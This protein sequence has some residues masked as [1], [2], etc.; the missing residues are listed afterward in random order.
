MF[1]FVDASAVQ[2]QIPLISDPR[3]ELRMEVAGLSNSK[4]ADS[5]HLVLGKSISYLESRFRFSLR[6]ILVR[7]DSDCSRN[8]RIS[9]LDWMA[10]LLTRQA[11]PP[12]TF[13]Q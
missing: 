12:Y 1:F 8:T 6:D 7:E 11:M 9:A 2:R 4:T 5:A 13:R 3:S 10:L